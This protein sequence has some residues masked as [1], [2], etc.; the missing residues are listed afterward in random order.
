MKGIRYWKTQ[1]K[2]V[3]NI[4]FVFILLIFFQNRIN[5]WFSIALAF[6]VLQIACYWTL[7]SQ[8]NQLDRITNA[9]QSVVE[10]DIS[11]WIE[12]DFNNELNLLAQNVNRLFRRLEDGYFITKDILE[13]MPD[14]FFIYDSEMKIKYAN[15]ALT[16]MVGFHPVEVGQIFDQKE[17]ITRLRNCVFEGK[18][19]NSLD[20]RIVGKDGQII[21]LV[22]SVWNAIDHE[23]N[24]AEG[25]VNGKD[26]SR[27]TVLEEE[28]KRD[29]MFIENILESASLYSFIVVDMNGMIKGW[30]KGAENIFG[31]T[32]DEVLDKPVRITFIK[33]DSGDAAR[34]Q[35]QRS[36]EVFK[37]GKAIFTMTRRRKNGE[38]FPLHCTVTAL[39]NKDGEVE[40]FLLFVRDDTEEEKKDRVISDQIETAKNLAKSSI[41]IEEF[42]HVVEDIARQT[43]LLALNAAVEAARAGEHGVGFGVVS[44][45]IRRL[46]KRSSDATKEIGTLIDMIKKDSRRVAEAS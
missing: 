26:F 43:N 9:I 31:W 8:K 22:I 7:R 35:R 36:K 4:T 27:Y 34:I 46:A 29:K 15:K 17:L 11:T 6:I 13:R 12:I 25:F 23:R 16:D 30:N 20:A 10:G 18:D 38:E 32:K 1:H 44:D 45:E 41:K 40:G 33:D 28:M 19:F 5:S 37:K 39:K 2:I 14:P 42:L 24:I 3:V 21:P